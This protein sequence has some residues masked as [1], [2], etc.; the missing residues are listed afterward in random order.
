M[1]AVNPPLVTSVAVEP[2]R[3]GFVGRLLLAWT[4]AGGVVFGGFMS[5]VVALL[6]PGRS[7]VDAVAGLGLFGFGLVAG[8]AHGAM[9]AWFGRPRSTRAEEAV[10][11]LVHGIV[12]AVPGTLVA[13]ALSLSIASGPAAWRAGRPA[14]WLGS[15]AAALLSLGVCAWASALGVRA[16]RNALHRW[17]ERRPGVTIAVLSLLFLVALFV[18]RRPEIWWTDIRVTSLGAVL[19]AVGVTIWVAVPLEVAVLHRLY[20]NRRGGAA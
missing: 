14:F 4:M 10:T 11:R 15:G 12:L 2:V 13:A 7:T 17:P 3:V 16:L 20:R 8:F 1:N 9:L 19:L 6:D 18:L 5:A